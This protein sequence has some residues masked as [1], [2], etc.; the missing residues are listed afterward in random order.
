[1]PTHSSAPQQLHLQSLLPDGGGYTISAAGGDGVT[2]AQSMALVP[3]SVPMSLLITPY[4]RLLV[5]M[6]LAVQ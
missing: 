5:M 1:M 4:G 2:P 3:S 6:L